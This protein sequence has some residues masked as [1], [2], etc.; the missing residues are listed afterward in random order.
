MNFS[1][2]PVPTNGSI[3]CLCRAGYSYLKEYTR[4]LWCRTARVSVSG[5]LRT[6]VGV[7]AGA[8]AGLDITGCCV[9]CV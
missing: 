3:T 6:C 4:S 2:S 9:V 5:S 7:G 8:G 1:R